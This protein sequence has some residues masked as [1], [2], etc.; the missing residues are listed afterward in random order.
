MN[1]VKKIGIEYKSN[2][3]QT[4]VELMKTLHGYREESY[5]KSIGSIDYV[6]VEKDSKHLMRAL[7]GEDG[8]SS[9]CYLENVNQLIEAMKEKNVDE[10]LLLANRFT[11][12]ARQKIRKKTNMDYLSSRVDYHYGVGDLAY[13]IQQKT[14][15]LCRET[16]G[17][18]PKNED[19]CKGR[20]GG[21]YSCPVRRV[22]DDATF[23]AEMG[24]DHVL[25]EDF[26]KL[27]EIQENKG[28]SEA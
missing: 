8:S 1:K 28:L 21:R 14:V 2:W 23:H 20:D 6:A 25:L 11:S 15:E 18:P 27:L 13:A 10:A 26:Q 3:Q 5:D 9:P 19:N 7:V 16:C 17:A 24:W 22:S 12:S 4:T